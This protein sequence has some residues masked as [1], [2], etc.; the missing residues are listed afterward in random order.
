MARGPTGLRIRNPGSDS[1]SPP[2]V[3]E[4]RVRNLSSQDLIGTRILGQ[5]LN[6]ASPNQGSNGSGLVKVQ[7]RGTGL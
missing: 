7:A 3:R 5:P 4:E 1:Y 6:A 2:D